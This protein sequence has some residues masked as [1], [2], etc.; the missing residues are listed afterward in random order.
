MAEYQ[1]LYWQ[2]IPASFR[3]EEAGEKVKV[4]LDARFQEMIDA[5]ATERG[6]TDADEYLAHWKWGEPQQRP[7]SAQEVAEAVKNDLEAQFPA[8]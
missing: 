1:V 8:E 4:E 6:C 5:V 7:G 2:E 3:V